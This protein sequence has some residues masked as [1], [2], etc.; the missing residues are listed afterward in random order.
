MASLLS[1]GMESETKKDS[2]RAAV[3]ASNC[4]LPRNFLLYSRRHV[5]SWVHVIAGGGVP[6]AGAGAATREQG[7]FFPVVGL[8]KVGGCKTGVL[9]GSVKLRLLV[10]V[11]T[12]CDK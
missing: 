2:P 8:R 12:S 5:R 7:V 9:G 10:R 3:W 6:D 1:A 11:Y 4:S